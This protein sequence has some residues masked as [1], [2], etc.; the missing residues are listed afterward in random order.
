MSNYAR[1]EVLVD[2]D[3]VA[4]HL[5]DPNIRLVE[6]NEDVLLYDTGHV[7]G[8]VN[9]DWHSDLNDPLQRDY[10]NPEQFAALLS[11][12]GISPERDGG[13]IPRDIN[14]H[15]TH[16]SDSGNASSSSNRSGVTRAWSVTTSLRAIRSS[17]GNSS[18]L[19]TASRTPS[20]AM[21]IMSGELP[22]AICVTSLSA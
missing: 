8:A 17:S 19:L 15:G 18:P 22:P 2:T 16:G 11:R 14:D 12:N 4:A 3:W 5:N 1:P 10:I 6:S 13:G 9:I 20:M 21:L 7:P